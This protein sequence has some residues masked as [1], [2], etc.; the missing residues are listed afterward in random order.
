[1]AN[2]IK[3]KVNGLT[4]S[5][6]RALTLLYVLHNS[7]CGRGSAAASRNS[8]LLRSAG[9]KSRSV[10]RRGDGREEHHHAG[11]ASGPVRL[12]A[13]RRLLDAALQQAR[14]DVQQCRTAAAAEQVDQA[15]DLLATTKNPSETRSTAMNG[16]SAL[17]DTSKS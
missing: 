13:G 3:L 1:M 11:R 14:I 6:A 2:N 16:R 10:R 9:R 5:V 12:L 8:R 17:Q 7:S 15:A 4:H